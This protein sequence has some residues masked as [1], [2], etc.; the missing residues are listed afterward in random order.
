MAV[1][2]V[3]S[4]TGTANDALE[5]YNPQWIKVA[6]VTGTLVIT[7]SGQGTTSAASG[8]TAYVLSESG[9]T[10]ADYSVSADITFLAPTLVGPTMGLI[11]RGA[12]A[13]NSHYHARYLGGSPGALQILRITNGSFTTLGTFSFS[14]VTNATHNI[15]FTIAG[16]ELNLYLDGDTTPVVTATDSTITYQGLPGIRSQN[17]I[18]TRLTID[19]FVVEQA[20]GGTQTYSFT[21]T[22]G[23]TVSG[24]SS[25]NTS[26]VTPSSGGASFSGAAT[27]SFGTG[28]Q[29][30]SVVGTGGMA[31]VST[32]PVLRSSQYVALGGLLFS[33]SGAVILFPDPTP[34]STRAYK[35]GRRPRFRIL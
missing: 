21:G 1:L 33:G 4:F 6:G 17:A 27:I 11:L 15:K 5:V 24:T 26:R 23:L 12:T 10:S 29:S 31:I 30:L 14:P 13:T 22:G 35:R 7:A 18:S 8:T 25:I 34:K 9:I 3:E 32:V 28:V 19:N 20:D 2:V 16:S